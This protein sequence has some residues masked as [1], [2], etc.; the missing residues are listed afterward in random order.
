MELTDRE[1]TCAIV[2]WVIGVVTTT[3]AILVFNLLT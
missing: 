2:G 3:C 1:E